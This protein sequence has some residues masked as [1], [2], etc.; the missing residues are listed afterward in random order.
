MGN[1][2][3]KLEQALSPSTVQ[4]AFKESSKVELGWCLYKDLGH[5]SFV[6][7][8]DDRKMFLIDFVSKS[9]GIYLFPY[10][11]QQVN[12]KDVC[13]VI[14]NNEV[15]EVVFKCL[16]FRANPGN[17]SATNCRSF[18]QNTAV[19]MLEDGEFFTKPYCTL[20]KEILALEQKQ[21][22]QRC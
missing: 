11:Q 21:K 9:E 14:P 3:A 19:E 7:L 13:F 1:T 6:I 4:D 12:F 22:C 8:I 18:L 15:M 20:Y 5:C 2:G 16:S 10:Q 17:V